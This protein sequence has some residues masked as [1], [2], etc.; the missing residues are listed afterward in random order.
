MGIYEGKNLQK[1][2]NQ[3]LR[4][5]KKDSW[6]KKFSRNQTTALN[7]EKKLSSECFT[8]SIFVV[9]LSAG[10][11]NCDLYTFQLSIY[12]KIV[13]SLIAIE[14]YIDIYLGIFL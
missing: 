3:N 2:R 1:I 8:F 14:Y 4:N 11:L 6:L 10:E 7:I 12:M 9:P 13:T 5:I